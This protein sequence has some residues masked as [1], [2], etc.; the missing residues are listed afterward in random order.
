MFN[1]LNGVKV[2]DLT[3]IVL[4]P[5]A[6]QFLGDFGADVIKVEAPSGDLFRS[7]R[8]GQ[9]ENMGAPFLNCN[10]NKRSIILDLTK[11][12]GL[13]ALHRLISTAD[14]FV[15]NMRSKSAKKLGLSYSDLK[16]IKKDIIYCNA[17]GYGAG[18]AYEN[19]P[20]YDDTVQ[21]ASGLAYLNADATGAPKYLPTVLCDKVAGLHLA[22]A[23][24]AGVAARARSGRGIAIETPMFESMAAFLM[25][26]HLSGE[27]FSPANGPVG[28]TRLMSAFRKPFATKDGY[29]SIIPY[30]GAHWKKF[31]KLIKRD[32]LLE[33]ERVNDPALR[34]RSLDML[35]AVVAEATHIHTTGEWLTLLHSADIP[36][37]KVNRLDD[38]LTDEHLSDVG[39]F[40]FVDHPT[41]GKI[42]NIRSAFKM[43]GAESLPDKLAPNL[44][45][46]S[47]EILSEAGFNDAEVARIAG[48]GGVIMSG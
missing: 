47:A 40:E 19:D 36:C 7:V 23:I 16:K 35:Y 38:L 26:E 28:Y 2:I 6:T 45:G 37:A 31:L 29:I 21:A 1:I 9:S 12:E 44:G 30:N 15:H 5:Y 4:G 18:G 13:E 10:R 42:R 22:I 34:S 11:P 3:T 8:P 25:V 48:S 33:D 24:L 43:D 46:N 41:E 39:L 17:C 27:T 20:A 32:D 14:V